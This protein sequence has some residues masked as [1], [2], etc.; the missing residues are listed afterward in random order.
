MPCV[1]LAHIFAYR[2]TLKNQKLQKNNQKNLK[3]KKSSLRSIN[4]DNIISRTRR[5]SS[6][7]TAAKVHKTPVVAKKG[8]KAAIPNP[9]TPIRRMQFGL[10]LPTRKEK[11][12]AL[13]RQRLLAQE[14]CQ[15][16]QE[17]RLLAKKERLARKAQAKQLRQETKAKLQE[18]RLRQKTLKEAT[19]VQGT[20]EAKI[21]TMDQPV[22]QVEPKPEV[23]GYSDEPVLL[24]DGDVIRIRPVRVPRRFVYQS[25]VAKSLET[26]SV[27][28]V[29]T[30]P[31]EQAVNMTNQDEK[32]E[33]ILKSL[34][35][36]SI[37]AVKAEKHTGFHK[38]LRHKAKAPKSKN[39]NK[40][41]LYVPTLSTRPSRD[42]LINAESR[43]GSQIF[44]P[45]P[46]GHRRE[47]FHYRRG[48]WI[49]H[50]D[51]TD[52]KRKDHD[53][54]VRYEVRPSGI[55]KKIAA[56]KYFKLEG[57]E[58]ENFRQATHA[59]L[60]MIKSYLYQEVTN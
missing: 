4:Q 6:A 25:A 59:Y 41:T 60:M 14:R 26:P 23:S 8:T 35:A 53:L 43:L 38:I 20:S 52:A 29:A 19:K 58:L 56:G 42:E 24:R 33:D 15:L 16:A 39:T 17:K 12:L 9:G 55:Y 21:I 51:W 13:A 11:K 57:A 46:A 30:Q 49:W 31:A 37:K 50:E 48:I 28:Q 1:S 10:S 27:Q 40:N 3:P 7:K 45:I 32:A 44:G 54:T 22:V 34:A 18:E 2:T 5:A 36:S 47:F